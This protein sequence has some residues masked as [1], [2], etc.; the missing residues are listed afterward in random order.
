MFFSNKNQKQEKES[1]R[2][3]TIKLKEGLGNLKTRKKTINHANPFQMMKSIYNIVVPN[4]H[5]ELIH[6]FL[7]SHY[8]NSFI[9]II[10]IIN[11]VAILLIDYS[12]RIS[13]ESHQ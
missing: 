6:L 9:R 8:F 5:E 10:T 2:E 1:R 4:N 7:T 3:M 12:F 11:F 13:A